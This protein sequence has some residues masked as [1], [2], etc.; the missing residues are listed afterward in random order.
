MNNT[1]A[2]ARL[3]SYTECCRGIGAPYL[4]RDG[5]TPRICLTGRC[6]DVVWKA[7]HAPSGFTIGHHTNQHAMLN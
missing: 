5:A 6:I 4:T 3:T 2:R 7:G 1:T